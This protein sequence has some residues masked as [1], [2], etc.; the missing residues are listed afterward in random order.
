MYNSLRDV[1]DA[2]GKSELKELENAPDFIKV[3]SKG[4]KAISSSD[5]QNMN[6]ED[7]AIVFITKEGH[8]IPKFPIHNTAY[9]WM[10]IDS[11]EKSAHIMP[12]Q[13]RVVA[14]TNIKKACDTFGIDYPNYIGEINDN[15]LHDNVYDLSQDHTVSIEPTTKLAKILISNNPEAT[16]K[17]VVASMHA[18]KMPSSD[19]ALSGN[20]Y[21]IYNKDLIKEASDY[22]DRYHEDFSPKERREFALNMCKQASKLGAEI[23]DLLEKYAGDKF[24]PMLEEHIELRKMYA[25]REDAHAVYDALMDKVASLNVDTFSDL[26]SEVD[27]AM[28]LDDM[29]DTNISDPYYSTIEKKANVYSAYLFEYNDEKITGLQL[30]KLAEDPTVLAG[31]FDPEL[32][33]EFTKFPIVVFES[34]PLPQKVLIMKAASGELEKRTGGFD[35]IGGDDELEDSVMEDEESDRNETYNS[36]KEASIIKD[37]GMPSGPKTELPGGKALEKILPDGPLATGVKTPASRL[38]SKVAVLKA[39]RE[40]RDERDS[41]SIRNSLRVAGKAMPYGAMFGLGA[42]YNLDRIG[43][44][45][46][47]LRGAGKGALLGAGIGLLAGGVSNLAG[48]SQRSDAILRKAIGKA[49]RDPNRSTMDTIKEITRHYKEIAKTPG[50]IK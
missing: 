40:G 8:A 2:I 13:A 35:V 22:F 44:E 19:F 16:A 39:Y 23:S 21:P 6:S 5:T 29:W 18:D 14:A 45:A 49:G 32:V 24:S 11:F 28:G 26:L 31:Y 41:S 46:N 36:G 7:F 3:A 48:K 15:S 47:A 20:R 50:E 4:A 27:K 25:D 42:G 43:R 17:N 10:A 38:Q 33:A 30:A 1:V 37:P 9:A 34:L 12:P